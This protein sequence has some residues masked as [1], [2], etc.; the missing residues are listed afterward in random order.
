MAKTNKVSDK[1]IIKLL[2]VRS[3]ERDLQENLKSF[4]INSSLTVSNITRE[5]SAKDP[6]L[7]KKIDDIIDIINKKWIN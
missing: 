2:A 1:F 4:G 7:L 6:S 5:I 3:V